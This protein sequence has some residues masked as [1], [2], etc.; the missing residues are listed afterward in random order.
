MTERSI[1][2]DEAIE[3]ARLALLNSDAKRES[4]GKMTRAILRAA[5]ASLE[6]RG[7]LRRGYGGFK[8]SL[9][10]VFS[11]NNADDG[12]TLNHDPIAIIKLSD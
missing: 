1:F 3:A 9:V 2:D 6:A 10:A 5:E 4:F 12:S 7:K 11:D 8:D